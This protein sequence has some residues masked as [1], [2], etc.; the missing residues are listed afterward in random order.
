[1]QRASLLLAL[2]S[3]LSLAAARFTG[4]QTVERAEARLTCEEQLSSLEA[5]FYR[6][7]KIEKMRET[8]RL[9]RK[10]S[11]PAETARFA[12]LSEAFKAVPAGNMED[13][14]A[15]QEKAKL[16]ARAIV[17]RAHFP[18][19]NPESGSPYDAQISEKYSEDG[20]LES[21]MEIRS[22]LV[23]ADPQ[24]HLTFWM[25]RNDPAHN[26]RLII[27]L[28][29]TGDKSQDYASWTSREN[30]T[31]R[32]GSMLDFLKTFLPLNCQ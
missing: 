23:L 27:N 10:Q 1:M 5:D 13:L 24:P 16:M 31:R 18:L 11:T 2:V 15:L 7:M 28:G 4:A 20:F 19:L 9:V 8:T 26:P 22:L 6:Q 14:Y 17:K 12:S 30:Y 32:S 3:L 21:T 29:I 25:H